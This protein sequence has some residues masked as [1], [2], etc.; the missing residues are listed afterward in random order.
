[1]KTLTLSLKKQ[2]FELIKAGIKKEEYRAALC[3][4]TGLIVF[5][6]EPKQVTDGFMEISSTLTASS[7]PSAT[8]RQT[9]PN[10]DWSL[11][12]RKS[13]S[14][15]VALNVQTK[16]GSR[17]SRPDQ[18]GRKGSEEGVPE[19]F[20]VPLEGD[21]DFGGRRWVVTKSCPTLATPWPV[22]CQAPLSMGFSR[23]ECWSWV[24]LPSPN[25]IFLKR[26]LVFPILLV[27]SISLH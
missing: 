1:M 13:A 12:T 4:F 20:R 19:N 9:T 24:P 25:L 22:A 10:A 26:S 3:L 14:A 8:R 2:W 7:L 16:Q 23:Q 15:R 17:P 6:K 5:V 27:S 21:R 11:R 18:E